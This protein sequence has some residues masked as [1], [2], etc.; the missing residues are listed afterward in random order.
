M[1]VG[2]R[3]PGRYLPPLSPEGYPQWIHWIFTISSDLANT[4]PA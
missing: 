4:V 3:V 2:I 1:A